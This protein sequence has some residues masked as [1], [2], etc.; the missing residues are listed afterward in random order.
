MKTIRKFLVRNYVL[1]YKGNFF[2]WKYNAPRASKI[3]YPQM[4]ITGYIVVTNIN[5]PTPTLLIW[6]LYGLLALSFWF[7]FPWFG[8]GYFSLFPPK[9]EELD[10]FQ[11]FQYGH[12]KGDSLSSEQFQEWLKIAQKFYENE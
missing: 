2:G 6:I 10:D 4:V 11:K 7:G 3:L 12:F 5:W 9:W 1:D 8:L